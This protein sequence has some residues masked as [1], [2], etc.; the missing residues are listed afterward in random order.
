MRRRFLPTAALAAASTLA[1]AGC[2]SGADS[3]LHTV[4]SAAS[5]TLTQTV[6]A[7]LTFD[8]ADAFGVV[9][10][11][12]SGVFVFPKGLGYERI[13]LPK[14]GHGKA[15]SVYLVHM[16]RQ[17]YL[18]PKAEAGAALP[19]GK[20]WLSAALAGRASAGRAFPRFLE[21]VE[22]LN[23]QL[24]LQEIV[25]GAN[26]SSSLG[27]HVV[28]HVPHAE[29]RVSISLKQVVSKATGPLAEAVKSAVKTQMTAPG[30]P[31]F[32]RIV[33]WVDGAGRVVRLETA[34]RGSGL[35]RITEMLFG[36]GAKIKPSLP[37]EAQTASIDVVAASARR[38][39]WPWVLAAGG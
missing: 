8:G 37:T 10:A 17:V 20:T 36:F 39:G 1:L 14:V 23:P 29:Y 15:G 3:S 18:E 28:D 13:D 16:P 38:P 19:S 7:H 32:V 21:Q 26:A 27:D 33:V 25:W 35:G 6:A 22:A 2:G 30:G 4:V 34:V 31:S 5:L 24:L 12:A 11:H 9:Q